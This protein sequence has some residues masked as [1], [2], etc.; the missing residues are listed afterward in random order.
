MSQ[1]YFEKDDPLPRY[2]NTHEKW[3]DDFKLS[4]EMFD[5]AGVQYQFIDIKELDSYNETNI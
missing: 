5:E 1:R 3:V 2:C 4:S